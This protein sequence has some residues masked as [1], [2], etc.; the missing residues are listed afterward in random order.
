M[1]F[2]ELEVGV[3]IDDK[4][5][6]GAHYEVTK[7]GKGEAELTEVIP[8][9]SD[10]TPEVRK[11]KEAELETYSF[12]ENPNP[13]KK[14]DAKVKDGVLIVDGK[15][16]ILGEL[17][18][19]RLLLTVPGEAVFTTKVD[20]AEDLCDVFAYSVRS[21]R[22]NRV[23]QN[24]S[25]DIEAVTPPEHDRLYLLVENVSEMRDVR[26][27]NGK[28][29]VVNGEV[30]QEKAFVRAGIYQY[31]PGRYIETNS[32]EYDEYEEEMVESG[33]G[34]A[35]Q[36][37]IDKV[38]VLSFRDKISLLVTSTESFD[39]NGV[40]VDSDD[41]LVS[42]YPIDSWVDNNDEV[43]YSVRSSSAYQGAV[44]GE[45]KSVTPSILN[46]R[47]SFTIKSDNQMLYTNTGHYPVFI[48]GDAVSKL[49]GYNTCIGS[50]VFEGGK[51]LV[52]SYA[53]DNRK[54]KRV[55]IE[56]RPVIGKIVT[57]HDAD[58]FYNPAN[59][60]VVGH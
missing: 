1:L 51:I 33:D 57:V 24:V 53:N 56:E 17:V 59:P 44:E 37:P 48:H 23:M 29:V 3:V 20:D 28:P 10:A 36:A 9:G 11:L 12:Y 60:T 16:A 30:Q 5:G 4:L 6:A 45:L 2:N 21:K 54:I 49:K 8:E 15:P 14:P 25:K 58:W 18:P 41:T 7:L 39:E 42:I 50:R 43:R 19:E 13:L 38:E 32:L 22:T 34:I 31:I 35:V 46:G 47:I 55:E 27:E 52:L 40:I 26:D